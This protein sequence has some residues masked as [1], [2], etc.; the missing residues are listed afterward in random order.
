MS[1]TSACLGKNSSQNSVTRRNVHIYKS[2]SATPVYYTKIWNFTG[3]LP[4]DNR[5]RI[6]TGAFSP[7]HFFQFTQIH[8][9]TTSSI[10]MCFR[11]ILNIFKK[12]YRYLVFL[13]SFLKNL[14]LPRACLIYYLS[15]NQCIFK[16]EL[17]P[18]WIAPPF[19][20]MILF[21]FSCSSLI[22]SVKSPCLCSTQIL[23]S[24]E[25]LQFL[26]VPFTCCIQ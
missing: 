23:P 18:A 14:L 5:K 16:S 12:Q 25:F 19:I 24:F 13:S 26:S 1:F 8:H 22:L 11:F 2:Q 3:A 9:F 20:K 15:T 21:L 17:S 4:Q 10:Y 6:T 7:I